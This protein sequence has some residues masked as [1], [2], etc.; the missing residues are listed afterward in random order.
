MRTAF[1]LLL[2]AAMMAYVLASPPVTGAIFTT[3]ADGTKVNGNIY[4]D[5]NDVYLNGGP[6]SGCSQAGLPDGEYFYQVTDPSGKVMLSQD[7]VTCRT[8][9]VSKGY[10][11][12]GGGCT[13]AGPGGAS[14]CH[15]EVPYPGGCPGQKQDQL[16]PYAD[17]PNPG[18]EYKAWATPVS[19]FDWTN[20]QTYCSGDVANGV[21]CGEYSQAERAKGF[22]FGF[23]DKKSKTDNYKVRVADIPP[24]PA[25]S[26]S[27]TPAPTPAATRPPTQTP[28]ATSAPTTTPA[29]TQPPTAEPTSTPAATQRPST[30]ASATPGP[31]PIAGSPSATAYPSTSVSSTGAPTQAPT[32]TPAPTGQPTSAPT[33]TPAATVPASPT[34]AATQPGTPVPSQSA[35][36]TQCVGGGFANN[37]GASSDCTRCAS[38]NLVSRIPV[39][40]GYDATYRVCNRCDNNVGTIVIGLEQPVE[41]A[42]ALPGSIKSNLL[43][44][45]WTASVIAG[46]PKGGQEPTFRGIQLASPNFK[47]GLRKSA[48]D[49]F[50][51]TLANW[52]PDWQENFLVVAGDKMDFFAN[53]PV[54]KCAACQGCNPN[55]CPPG[56]SGEN[57]DQC[58]DSEDFTW[59][60]VPTGRGS[61]QLTRLFGSTANRPGVKAGTVDADGYELTCNCEKI[62]HECCPDC[63]DCDDATGLCQACP[64][65]ASIL[66]ADAADQCCELPTGAVTPCGSNPCTGNS[67]CVGATLSSEGSCQCA[68][69]AD[70]SYYTGDNCSTLVVPGAPEQICADFDCDDCSELA[71]IF[72]GT[73]CAFCGGEC[74][75]AAFCDSGLEECESGVIAFTPGYC[76]GDCGGPDKGTCNTTSGLCICKGK[77]TGLNCGSKNGL[78]YAAIGGLAAGAVAGIVI[79]SVFAVALIAGLVFFVSSYG[80]VKLVNGAEFANNASFESPLYENPGLTRENLAYDSA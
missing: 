42:S 34:P 3:I 48:C 54:G 76:P 75:D 60:C 63:A 74:R 79:A 4:A 21:A 29:A 50:T 47:N 40:N 10:W 11:I 37:C 53:I 61:Y 49:E 28:A 25:P 32:G 57:C 33:T 13:T 17:T 55:T 27:S 5:K 58:E 70:G 65:P 64:N 45:T 31:T 52:N 67:V 39:S 20:Y 66:T 14:C 36:P 16:M 7:P 12:G 26:A 68:T 41:L 23:A 35:P 30:S 44:D 59:W 69:L 6:Q 51:F 78:N 71:E 46:N 9:I 77:N 62:T 8:A 22:S 19:D 18:G 1:V 73:A 80:A 24:P 15:K 72:T 56:F 43:K 2:S 38:V